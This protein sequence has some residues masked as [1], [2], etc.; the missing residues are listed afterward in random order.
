ML[1]G[2]PVRSSFLRLAS[3]E[4]AHAP[5]KTHVVGHTPCCP[6]RVVL[7]GLHRCSVAAWTRWREQ[8]FVVPQVSLLPGSCWKRPLYGEVIFVILSP[9]FPVVVVPEG[10]VVVIRPT[11]S[12]VIEISKPESIHT[13]YLI[14]VRFV[15]VSFG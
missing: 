1:L 7:V 14:R 10:V 9:V 2:W 8:C 15:F 6:P 11:V 13:D 12:H 5:G 3:V 4:V